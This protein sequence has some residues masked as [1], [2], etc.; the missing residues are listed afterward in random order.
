MFDQGI[1]IYCKLC[2]VSKCLPNSLKRDDSDPLTLTLNN[3]KNYVMLDLFL[4]CNF[5]SRQSSPG[6]SPC[7]F[8][9]VLE[10]APILCTYC[11]CIT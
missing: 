2:S 3:C 6:R 11:Q 10:L 5:R 8:S 7:K 9:K 4:F 1:K